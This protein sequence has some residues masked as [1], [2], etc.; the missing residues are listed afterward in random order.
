MAFSKDEMERHYVSLEASAKLAE[1]A[2]KIALERD[3]DYAKAVEY[4]K[5]LNPISS[6]L[7][8]HGYLSEEEFCS[9]SMTTKEAGDK[10]ADMAKELMKAEKITYDQAIARIYASEENEELLRSYAQTD[11]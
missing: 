6:E 3:W 9:Y 8:K 11:Y 2:S 7:E 10:L 5:M 4:I 1:K